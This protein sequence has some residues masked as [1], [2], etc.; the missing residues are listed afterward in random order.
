MVAPNNDDVIDASDEQPAFT[1]PYV[2]TAA[3]ATA[4]SAATCKRLAEEAIAKIQG[5][6]HLSRIFT[7]IMADT[8]AV[9]DN[10]G[11]NS[12]YYPERAWNDLLYT[13]IDDV[14]DVPNVFGLLEDLGYTVKCDHNDLATVHISWR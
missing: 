14:V 11:G 6:E 12:I 4:R 3:Q 8:K 10:T 9:M 1:S 5:N 13:D 7:K 2:F